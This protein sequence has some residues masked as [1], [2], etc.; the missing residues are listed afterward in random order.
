MTTPQ[1][2]KEK[3][4]R[5]DSSLPIMEVSSEEFQL[6][7]KRPKTFSIL[8][9]TGEKDVPP[10]TR[11][12][13]VIPPFGSSLDKEITPAMPKKSTDSPL[14]THPGKT[15]PKLG[16]FEKYELIK[17]RNQTLS[18]STYAQFRKQSSTTQHRL[19][20]AFDTEK[21]Q[22]HME[23]LE[24]QV[25]D[26]KVITDYKRATFEFQTKDVHP[27]DQMDLHKQTGEMVF[28]KL[29][30]ASTFVAKLQVLLNNSQTQL[31]MEK[32]SSFAK[33]NII[34]TLEEPVLKIGYDPSNVKVAEEMIKKKN[35][36]IASLRKQLKLPPTKDSQ[37]KEI[38]EKEGKKDEM[39]K[40]LMEQS[41][42]LKEMEA[43]MERF[44][45]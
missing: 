20:S 10:T 26:P 25:P 42:H 2:P 23:F 14:D 33:D 37:A 27:A 29:V 28:H 24:T 38:A 41:A 19:L 15:G 39:L 36:N 12:K 18:S 11:T 9:P 8:G 45:K 13:P 34:K 31:K 40:L 4:P 3:R 43:E 30:H 7:T 5:R 22:M 17:K 35:A 16:I 44:L 21:G 6:H 32:I 1:V